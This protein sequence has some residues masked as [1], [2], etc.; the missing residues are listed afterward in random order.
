[1]NKQY[2]IEKANK[3]VEKA[4]KEL[5]L[6]TFI[7]DNDITGYDFNYIQNSECVNLFKSTEKVKSFFGNYRDLTIFSKLE[8]MSK[9]KDFNK[10]ELIAVCNTISK[11]Q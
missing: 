9:Y 4:K 7:C 10:V 8:N 5:E 2:F 6:V 3:Q 1:M 11:Q